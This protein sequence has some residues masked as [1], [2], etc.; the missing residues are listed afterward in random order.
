MSV[1]QPGKG[2]VGLLLTLGETGTQETGDL[3]DESLGSNEGVVLA[4]KLLDQLLVL[5][6]LLQV[7]NRH[8]ID[9]A[10][11]GTI[12]IM[13]VTEDAE[14]K[15]APISTENTQVINWVLCLLT[16]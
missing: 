13:L 8:G 16:R 7:I 10:V 6:E 1:M 11:L 9:T 14:K 2:G 4:S 3:L 12:E 5:V 15:N